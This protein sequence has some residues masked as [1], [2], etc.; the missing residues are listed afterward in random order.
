MPYHST[1]SKLILAL[2]ASFVVIYSVPAESKAVRTH[3]YQIKI[4]PELTYAAVNICFDGKV[5]E[6]LIVDYRKATKNLIQIPETKDGYIEFEGRYWKTKSLA[7]NACIDYKV[8]ISD[9][10]RKRRANVK[11]EALSYFS[12]NTWLWLPEKIKS[13]EEVEIKFD[14]PESYRVSAPWK[15]MDTKGKHFVVGKLPQDWGFTVVIGEFDLRQVSLQSGG[16]LNI[17]IMDNVKQKDNLVQW[18]KDT[19]ESLGRYLGKF[20]LDQLQVVM[21]QSRKSYRSPV[22]WG[23]VKRGSGFGIIL[24]VASE[25][26]I[27][28]FYRDW[29]VTHEFGH[30]LIPNV[31]YRDIWLSEG[32]ASYLQYVLMAQDNHLTHKQTWQRLYEGFERGLR[33]TVSTSKEQLVDTVKN[34]RRGGGSGRTKRIYWSGAVYFFLADIQLREKT[35][36]EM[37]LPKLLAKLNQ[38]C[39]QSTQEWT[40]VQLSKKLDELSD[41]Q[42]FSQLYSQ[43]AYS[44]EFPDF[45]S[46]YAK[47][48]ITAKEGQVKIET[49]TGQ[50]LRES[51]LL[52]P[53]MVDSTRQEQV[54]ER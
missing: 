10:K 43:I 18:V 2:L 47:L 53:K 28:D 35:N 49:Q 11:N 9:H 30:L 1:I 4:N 23:E 45:E 41:S 34:R 12:E 39:I 48:G 8:N 6:Y 42:I 7:D 44:Y 15:M 32:L 21:L 13:D 51:I 3:T 16:K 36:G 50:A 54:G 38:C 19:G 5:P 24:V 40:G 25:R 52:N 29:T 27:E 14:L 20:P 31:K 26:K 46:A 17:A 33:G 37:D 22:P